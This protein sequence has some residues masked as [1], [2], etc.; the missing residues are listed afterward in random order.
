MQQSTGKKERK[1]KEGGKGRR[2]VDSTEEMW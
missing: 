2:K 1:E